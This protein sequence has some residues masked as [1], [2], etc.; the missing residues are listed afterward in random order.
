MD[1]ILVVDDDSSIC[2]AFEQFFKNLNYTVLI[3]SNSEDGLQLAEKH[4]PDMVLL[5]V[6]LPGMSGLEALRQLKSRHSQMQIVIMSA[7]DNIANTIQSMRLQAFDFLPKPIDLNQVKLILEHATQLEQ[8]RA[9]IPTD[10]IETTSE[11]QLVGESQQMLEVWKMIGIMAANS[12]TVLI[13]GENGTGKGLVARAIHDNGTRHHHPFVIVDCGALPD[14]LLESELFGY[15]AGAFTGA[16]EKGKLGK[17][18]LA[19]GGTLFLDEIGN[20]SSALQMRLLRTLQDGEI[21][22][23][24]GT[25]TIS[26]NV[27]VIAATNANLEQSVKDGKF[28]EDLYY[29]LKRISINLPPLRERMQDISILAQHFLKQSSTELNRHFHGIDHNCLTL[30]QNYPWPGNIRELENAVKSAAILSRSDVILTH[31]LPDEIRNFVPS[32]LAIE[33][34]NISLFSEIFRM[35]VQKILSASNILSTEDRFYK[36]LIRSFDRELILALRQELSNNHSKMAKRL[37]ISRT[38][39]WQKIKALEL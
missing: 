39:L 20:M 21:D 33:T 18:E 22:R 36:A 32:N 29:R 7:Y 14:D 3:A 13:E 27:R 8:A 19:D 16:Q 11:L 25:R 34:E 15:E 17:F 6:Q 37:G 1:T 28:R 5:D 38:T 9:A 2:W 35:A 23:L 30:L 31:H 10:S 4:Q 12:M 26:I 24:G